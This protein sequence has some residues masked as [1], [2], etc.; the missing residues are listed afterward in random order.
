MSSFLQID[1]YFAPA[2]PVVM[3]SSETSKS[4]SS[5]ISCTL[6]QGP[7]FAVLVD[8]LVTAKLT[9]ALVKWIHETAPRK[10]LAFIYTTHAHADHY[11]G[12]PT[13]LRAFPGARSVATKAVADAISTSLKMGYSN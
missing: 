10:K 13:V 3:G 7:T 2:V 8:T 6:V 9:H 12:N 5:P 4:M 1:V 11:F